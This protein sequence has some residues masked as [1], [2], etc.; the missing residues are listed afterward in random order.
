[1]SAPMAF[2]ALYLK[3]RLGISHEEVALL[4]QECPYFNPFWG[5]PITSHLIH[6]RR[7]SIGNAFQT[8]NYIKPIIYYLMR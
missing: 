3:Q 4:I 2:G 1:M 5:S 6:P 7:F 8:M